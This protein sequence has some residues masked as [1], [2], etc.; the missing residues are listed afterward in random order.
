VKVIFLLVSLVVSANL[1]AKPQV[2]MD[3]IS[4]IEAATSG[5]RGEYTGQQIHMILLSIENY[6]RQEFARRGLEF[7][8]VG[9]RIVTGP[10]NTGCGPTDGTHGPFYCGN[11]GA[12][13]VNPSFF[14]TRES[15]KILGAPTQALLTFVLAHE[16]GHH[17]QN[18]LDVEPR[19]NRWALA[20]FGGGF[21]MPDI[22]FG[23][24]Y[25]YQADC[26]GGVYLSQLYSRD[27]MNLDELKENVVRMSRMGDDYIRNAQEA[28]Y[29]Q[30][31]RQRRVPWWSLRQ[32][33]S[34]GTSDGR[35]QWMVRGAKS[36][37]MSKCEPFDIRTLN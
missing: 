10:T 12:I 29:Y 26:L 28:E 7:H 31:L 27:L 4:C 23:P 14:Y 25:E 37:D 32:G 1:Y 20:R 19:I 17:I 21:Y 33:Y 35:Q 8:D 13:Y 36:G 5:P 9:Y 2:N 11:D 30:Q 3:D 18:L 15:V 22:D 34:H 16:F 6:W 24:Q